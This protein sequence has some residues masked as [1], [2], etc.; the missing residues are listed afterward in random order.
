MQSNFNK[1]KAH[2]TLLNT[3]LE[4]IY[5]NKIKFFRCTIS[6]KC[7]MQNSGKIYWIPTTNEPESCPSFTIS[8]KNIVV[9]KEQV[10][11]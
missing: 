5:N 6:S 2:Q 11:N 3:C 7:E 1:I 10:K 8:P 4:Y 9:G